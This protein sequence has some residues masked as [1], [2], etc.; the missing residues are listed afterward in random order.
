[1]RVRHWTAGCATVAVLLT[2]SGCYGSWLAGVVESFGTPDGP[3][4]TTVAGTGKAGFTGDGGQATSAELNEPHGVAVDAAGNIYIADT[5]NNRIRMVATDGTITTLA[6]T[7]LAG[8]VDGAATDAE[9]NNPM[10]L[11]VHGTDVFV[12]DFYNSAIR[13]IK[14]ATVSTVAGTGTADYG[15]DTGPAN[16]AKLHWPAGVAIDSAGHIYIADFDNTRIREF[17]DNGAITTV[18]GNGTG[19]YTGD[20][21]LATKAEINYPYDV[22]VDL[23]GNLYIADTTNTVIRRVDAS[24][25]VISTVAGNGTAGF[26]GDGGPA[27]SASMTGPTGVTVDAAGNL[28]IADWQNNVIRRVDAGGIIQTVAGNFHLGKGYAGDGNVAASAMLNLPWGVA[29][30]SHGNL[31]IADTY[32]NRIRKVSFGP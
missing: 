3:K 31:Y 10:S 6:G 24:T 5:N 28:Y 13:K 19:G 25:G 1:M 21:L 9:F 17:D 26:S 16:L 11:A 14:L 20:G 30:D 32:N 29:V 7:G 12:A 4:I 27:T 2:L 22:A 23:S 18:A 15:G 8:W